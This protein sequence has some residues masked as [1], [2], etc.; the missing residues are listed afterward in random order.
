MKTQLLIALALLFVTCGIIVVD[1]QATTHL[2]KGKISLLPDPTLTP[3]VLN[4]S[5]TQANINKTIC[6]SGWTSTIRPTSSYTT[7]LKVK[8]MKQYGLTGSTADYEEDHLISLELGGNPT[9]PKNL[10]PESYK[11]TPNAHEKDQ[12]ENALKKAVCAGSITLKQ[13][14]G[15]I[16]T[17]WVSYYQTHIDG[18]LGGLAEDNDDL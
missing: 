12:T 16:A 6:V 3:G 9:D 17:D 18:N 13:A 14:Q 11:T 7:A 8:Q 5:V 1:V 15:I 4:P 10:W 2:L